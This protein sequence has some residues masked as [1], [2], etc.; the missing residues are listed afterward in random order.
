MKRLE[1]RTAVITGGNSGIGLAIAQAFQQEGASVVIFGRNKETLKEAGAS[2]T[3]AYLPSPWR[4]R[5]SR[6]DDGGY[7][8]RDLML[9]WMREDGLDVVDFANVIGK[10]REPLAYFGRGGHYNSR[11]YHKLAELLATQWER[12]SPRI[13]PAR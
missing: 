12:Q 9:A 13:I 4:Y 1:G 10:D 3:I 2:F 11:G 7:A 5:R 8:D 6:G